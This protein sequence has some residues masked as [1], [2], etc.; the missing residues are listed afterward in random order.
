[1]SSSWLQ[2]ERGFFLVKE[3]RFF[4]GNSTSEM[5]WRKSRLPWL[6]GAWG[7]SKKKNKTQQKDLK[8]STGSGHF[9]QNPSLAGGL[10]AVV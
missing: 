3:L 1:M 7:F 4:G 6:A 10:S 2:A 9:W 8:L 5:P